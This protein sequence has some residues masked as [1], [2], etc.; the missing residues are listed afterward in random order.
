[1]EVQLGNLETML[2]ELCNEVKQLKLEVAT[3]KDSNAKTV[4]YN[5]KLLENILQMQQNNEINQNVIAIGRHIATLN[6]VPGVS[7]GGV[8]KPEVKKERIDIKEEISQPDVQVKHESDGS[9]S[10]V[11]SPVNSSVNS[12]VNKQANEQVN[13]Q[14]NK[15]ANEQT[16]KQ[17]NEQESCDPVEEF[18][19]KY[20][21]ED[22]S[23][24]PFNSTNGN[25]VT[26]KKM[27]P[28]TFKAEY[29]KLSKPDMPLSESDFA[30][31][32]T[33]KRVPR[34]LYHY[35]KL[36]DAGLIP[37]FNI[38]KIYTFITKQFASLG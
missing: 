13:E 17:A 18:F 19:V 3:L 26:F 20:Y 6:K 8:I 37:A 16:N 29:I 4:E 30:A 31:N 28:A 22:I 2:T 21:S 25:K 9:D 7:P 15:Q 23:F 14:V 27:I 11:N 10:P 33:D 38:Q 35:S 24:L 1:M 36:A 12:L 32:V 34:A 5:K